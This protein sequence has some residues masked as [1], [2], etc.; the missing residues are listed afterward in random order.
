VGTSGGA[1]GETNNSAVDGLISLSG[2]E[3]SIA[4]ERPPDL[5]AVRA[6]MGL[7]NIV[8]ESKQATNTLL[9][10]GVGAINWYTG[11]LNMIAIAG[12]KWP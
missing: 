10:A 4:A 7:M 1:G 12:L 2:T 9:F 5:G 11:L 8:N 6:A 3:I